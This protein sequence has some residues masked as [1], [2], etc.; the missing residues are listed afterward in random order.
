MLTAENRPLRSTN[1]PWDHL[2]PFLLAIGR[3]YLTTS[4][5][6]SCTLSTLRDTILLHVL[7]F[8]MDTLIL[9]LFRCL[10]VILNFMKGVCFMD[11][12]H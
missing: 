1:F 5:F 6:F 12:N 7:C 8:N 2:F 10:S 9:D 4:I 3:I 11:I